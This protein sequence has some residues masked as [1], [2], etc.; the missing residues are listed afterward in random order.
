MRL[1]DVAHIST[2]SLKAQPRRTFFLIVSTGVVFG[3]VLM[4]NLWWRTH[5]EE[6]SCELE[7][8]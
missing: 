4:V 6:L 2:K 8:A 5:Y 7:G 3:L 1:R